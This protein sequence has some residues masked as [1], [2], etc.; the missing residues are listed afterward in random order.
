MSYPTPPESNKQRALKIFL[1][2]GDDANRKIVEATLASLG[3]ETAFSTSSGADLLAQ[4]D[5]AAPD[6][7]IVGSQLESIGMYEVLNELERHAACPAIALIPPTE[8][9]R[10]R[11]LMSDQVMG[12]L[13][14]PASAIQ[15]R[16]AIHLAHK[17][18][19]QTVELQERADK[20]VAELEDTG[21]VET[22]SDGNDS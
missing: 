15:F 21:G 6:M 5:Q 16:P 17:R 1:G 10:A 7:V 4:C 18:Y 12:V 8:V 19:L 3:H 11:R 22:S 13:I 14:E 9:D 2:H 20:L